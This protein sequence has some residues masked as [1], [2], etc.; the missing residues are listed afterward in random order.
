MSYMASSHPKARNTAN[1]MESMSGP[2]Q[3]HCHKNWA[4]KWPS[5]RHW[6]KQEYPISLIFALRPKVTPIWWVW[7]RNWIAIA[8]W[9]KIKKARL[10]MGLCSSEISKIIMQIRRNCNPGKPIRSC[11]IRNSAPSAWEE[12]S[13][14]LALCSVLS[15]QKWLDILS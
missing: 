10:D 11:L 1:R 8:W 6:R 5:S 13:R 14:T 4:A 2:P 9:C 15:S 12:S 7:E 3:P